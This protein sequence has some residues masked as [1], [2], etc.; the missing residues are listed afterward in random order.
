MRATPTTTWPS[1]A[2][3]LLTL[4]LPL[5]LLPWLA[6]VGAAFGAEERRDSGLRLSL[7]TDRPVYQPGQPVRFRLTVS[8]LSKQAV[9]LSCKDSQRFDM[10][11]ADLSG[12]PRWRWSEDQMFAQMLSE[13]TIKPGESRVYTA[14]FTGKLVPGQYRAS[15]VIVCMEPPLSAHA[16]FTVQ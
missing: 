6:P 5:A 1:Y 13:D 16:V 4:V 8:N 11:V 10:T 15:G 14:V 9:I 12:K 7:E 3:I 2:W